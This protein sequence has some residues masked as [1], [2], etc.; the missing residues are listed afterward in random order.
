LLPN[1]PIV[2]TLM[3]QAIRFFETSV[4]TGDTQRNM[5]EN[6]ILH[7]HRRETLKSHISNIFSK[8]FPTFT[9]TVLLNQSW[10]FTD[11]GWLCWLPDLY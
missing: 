5:P 2:V 9:Q 6:G 7:S 4:L 10:H 8:N 1:S 3:S 11:N